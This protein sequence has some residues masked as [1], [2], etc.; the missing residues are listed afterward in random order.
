MKSRIIVWS[1]VAIVVIVGLLVVLNA[2]KTSRGPKVAKDMIGVEVARAEAQLD[3]LAAR[4]ADQRKSLKPG[5]GNERLDE[6]D[7]LLALAR[8]RF[9]QAKKS[10]DA[11]EAQQL[12][13]EGSKSLRKARRALELASKP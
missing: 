3:R 6:A 10:A 7:G 12:L 8:D 9:S 1:L 11:D 2:P 13:G 5:A 4:A